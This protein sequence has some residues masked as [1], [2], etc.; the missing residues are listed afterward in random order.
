MEI[1]YAFIYDI[2]NKAYKHYK[3]LQCE[4][5][6]LSFDKQH[7]IFVI[8]WHTFMDAYIN[9]ER[10]KNVAKFVRKYSKLPIYNAY[11]LMDI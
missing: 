11:G 4:D 5:F 2:I 10:V 9:M 3:C 8:G 6:Y 7:N 1:N